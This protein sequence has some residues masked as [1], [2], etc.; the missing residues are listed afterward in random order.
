[1][2]RQFPPYAKPLTERLK[3]GVVIGSRMC[4]LPTINGKNTVY[5]SIV[6]MMWRVRHESEL[7]C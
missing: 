5:S 1:M 3:F 7:P 2:K 6:L 4:S